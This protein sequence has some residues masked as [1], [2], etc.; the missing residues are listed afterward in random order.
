[1]MRENTR[2]LTYIDNK[3]ITI[4]ARLC[5]AILLPIGIALVIWIGTTV[6]QLD[7]DVSLL[8]YQTNEILT[9][10]LPDHEARIRHIETILFRF[11]RLRWEKRDGPES[12]NAT[13]P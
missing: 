6:N 3:L 9:K 7:K 11:D 10:K 13:T 5:S 1:M 2:L 12:D 8:V 4:I